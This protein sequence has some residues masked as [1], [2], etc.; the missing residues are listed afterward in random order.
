MYL[1]VCL[2][3]FLFMLLLLLQL[4]F[5][6]LGSNCPPMGKREPSFHSPL[7]SKSTMHLAAFTWSQIPKTPRKFFE[8]CKLL[9]A[10]L[11]YH[12]GPGPR[13]VRRGLR[14]QLSHGVLTVISKSEDANGDHL[15]VTG[16]VRTE[17]N[18]G[19]RVG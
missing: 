5:L 19:V 13:L 17:K 9:I 15:Q 14:E 3:V 7:E 6:L 8:P 4:L 18:Q 16:T 2:L 11:N 10:I 12:L 1:F